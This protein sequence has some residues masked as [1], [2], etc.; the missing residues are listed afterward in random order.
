MTHPAV[1]QVTVP[2][3]RTGRSLLV[4]QYGG[5]LIGRLLGAG[6][7]AGTLAV[8][9]R[10]SL[11][12]DFGRVLA[13]LGVLTVAVVVFEG[14][15]GSAMVRD[16]A[17]KC[18]GNRFRSVL[19]LNVVLSAVMVVLGMVVLG[20]FWVQTGRLQY[21]EMMPLVAWAAAE[22]NGDL[23]LSTALSVGR[24]E[25]S[26]VSL[27]QRRGFGLALFLTILPAGHPTLAL[28]SGLLAGSLVA[29][30]LLRRKLAD[31]L[32]SAG[33]R[34]P[35]SVLLRGARPFYLNSVGVQLRNLDVIAVTT[36]V[37]SA[38]AGVYGLPARMTAP[39][40]ILPT[41]VAAVSLRYIGDDHRAHG[42]LVRRLPV[43]TTAGMAVVMAVLIV[44]SP[45]L[46][47]LLFGARYEESA[48]PLRILA[49]GLVFAFLTSFQTSELQARGQERFAAIVSTSTGVLGLLLAALGALVGG[50]AGATVGI[51]VSYA[52][53]A[54][55]CG[56]RVQAMRRAR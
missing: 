19:R 29:N 7:Q 46:V 39:L 10:S 42:A 52:V 30:L 32:A 48:T 56:H 35:S 50:A 25:I 4:T 8:Y 21:L 15:L 23:L 13:V 17:V 31:V 49:V 47:N 2:P 5:V 16:S 6:L 33:P 18:D 27:L 45:Q 20:V 3:A 34:I 28:S 12:A 44:F 1:E 14:G 51:C 24:A 54:V 38:V 53:Q 9:A 43:L 22:K 11:Q 41:S 40:R 55:V 36:V 26:P 37:G